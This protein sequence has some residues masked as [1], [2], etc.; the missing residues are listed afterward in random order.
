VTLRRADAGRA[1]AEALDSIN[2]T[3]SFFLSWNGP[4]NCAKGCS[5]EEEEQGKI[6]SV[7]SSHRLFLP[8]QPSLLLLPLLSLFFSGGERG[9]RKRTSFDVAARCTSLPPRRAAASARVRASH[10]GTA[11]AATVYETDRCRR[12]WRRTPRRRRRGGGGSD[13]V[14]AFPLHFRLLPLSTTNSGG[15]GKRGEASRDERSPG[16]A[17]KAGHA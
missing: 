3:S 6:F 4:P 7:A 9:L 13:V 5:K 2:R 1:C 17:L 10:A 16:L 8:L 11:A 12:R 15:R 14:G